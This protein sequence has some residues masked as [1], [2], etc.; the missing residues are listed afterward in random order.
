M[1]RELTRKELKLE[2][3]SEM[4][5]RE[6]ELVSWGVVDG[7]FPE[8]E[9]LTLINVYL[10][11]N[12]PDGVYEDEDE[13][14]EVLREEA[15]IFELPGG[16]ARYRSRMAEG[17]RLL[18]RLRQI[19]HWRAWNVAQ[20]LIADYR[21]L[22]QPRRYPERHLELDMVHKRLDPVLDNSAM[23]HEI[24]DTLIG[25]NRSE[26]F[27]LADFQVN[28]ARRVLEEVRKGRK[29]GSIICAGTGSG[30]TLAFYLPTLVALARWSDGDRWTRCLSLY[31]RN[32][33]LKDQLSTAVKQVKQ[34]NEVLVSAGRRPLRVGAMFGAVPKKPTEPGHG[35]DQWDRIGGANLCPYLA[36]PSCDQVG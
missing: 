7:F 34:V 12:D 33:L 30:K 10:A 27:K 15:L 21:L 17:I 25:A 13:L 6:S 1:A 4:E 26:P 32:E 29:S 28:A 14:L 11:E 31:P 20:N 36:C 2:F 24:V 9:L 19:L 18:F 3:L 35:F 23:E 22:L 8:D 5:R 16:D